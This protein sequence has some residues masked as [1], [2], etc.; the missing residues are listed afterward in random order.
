ME[1]KAEVYGQI[2]RNDIMVRKYDFHNKITESDS[3]F[4]LVQYA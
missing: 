4:R 3:T 2:M 1:K